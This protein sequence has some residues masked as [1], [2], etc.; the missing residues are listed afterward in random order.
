MTSRNFFQWFQRFA[1]AVSVVSIPALLLAAHPVRRGKTKPE[2]KQ[3]EMF[4]AIKDGQLEVRFIPRNAKEGNVLIKNL[5]KQPLNVILPE[6][7]AGVPAVLAQ[8]GGLGGLG[9]G[10]GGGGLGGGGLGLGGGGL[11]LGGLGGGTQGVGG[12][13]GGGGMFNVP[14]EKVGKLKVQCVCLEHGKPDPNPRVKYEIK[15]IESYAK[16]PRVVELIRLFNS[17]RLSQRATQAAAWH[18][19]NN[20]SWQQLA[21]KRIKHLNG[22]SESYFSRQELLAAMQIATVAI[23]Q[24]SQRQTKPVTEPTYSRAGSYTRQ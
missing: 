11:G 21:N 5:T 13:F 20:M 7:F 14:P 4:Q 15:P 9:G 8:P 19:A 22:R 17:G 3:V 12:G 16:D 18:L 10:L 6:G 24:A 23:Q 1:L 2:P